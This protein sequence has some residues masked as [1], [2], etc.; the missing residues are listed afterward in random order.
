M[1]NSITN[2]TGLR[3]D[4]QS[5]NNNTQVFNN[6]DG[7]NVS[8]SSMPSIPSPEEPTPVTPPFSGY[9]IIDVNRFGHGSK[10]TC[11]TYTIQVYDREGNLMDT[12]T[13]YM[14]ER[15]YDPSLAEVAG[16]ATAI[17]PGEYQVI[18]S[19]LNEKSGY[20]ELLDVPGRYGIKIHGGLNYDHTKGCLMPGSTYSFAN[21]EYTIDNNMNDFRVFLNSYMNYSGGSGN[22]IIRVH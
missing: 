8:I 20:Y 9:V 10:T 5:A 22:V 17:S 12:K 1:K 21:G 14:L 19:T 15:A 4:F 16:S 18:P 3:D 6:Y 11:S 13:G 7:N 2:S